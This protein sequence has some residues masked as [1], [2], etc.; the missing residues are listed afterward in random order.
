MTYSHQLSTKIRTYFWALVAVSRTIFGTVA[1]TNGPS[2]IRTLSAVAFSQ[3]AGP[4]VQNSPG[5]NFSTSPKMLSEHFKIYQLFSLRL[6][7]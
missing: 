5:W 3:G 7:L 6:G 2:R 4:R 1:N